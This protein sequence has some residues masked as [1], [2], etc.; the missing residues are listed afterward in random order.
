M[1]SATHICGSECQTSSKLKLGNWLII[2][3]TE[4]VRRVE[5]YLAT[6]QKVCDLVFARKL[7]QLPLSTV[8]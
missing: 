1:V 8:S 2:S 6:C 7:R 4:Q 3:I 5:W